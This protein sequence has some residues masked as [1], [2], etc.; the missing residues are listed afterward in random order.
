MVYD[1][2]D[3]YD[4]CVQEKQ[5][6]SV[7]SYLLY[8]ISGYMCCGVAQR[9]WATGEILNGTACT[10]SGNASAWG[11]KTT[12]SGNIATA[13]G[14]E[15]IASGENATAF[16]SK[17]IASGMNATTFGYQTKAEKFL[18]T[19]FGSNT[20]AAV[21]NA[22]AFGEWTKAS[23]MCATAWGK[24][25]EGKTV[26]AE[27]DVSTAFGRFSMA[28][29]DNSLAALGGITEEGADNSAAIGNRAKVIC[30]DTVA[31]GSEAV[32]NRA[33]G[34][35]GFYF[36]GGATPA[37]LA[38]KSTHAAIAVGS[39]SVTRQIIGVAAGSQDTD[40]VNLAQLKQAIASVGP[41]G[42]MNSLQFAGDDGP[43][44]TKTDGQKLEILGGA[45]P[46]NLSENNIGVSSE[47]GALRIKLS[48]D[49]QGIHSITTESGV[50][51]DENGQ[52]AG[53]KKITGV[54]AG[55]AD[56][57]AVNVKQL[58]QAIAS[59]GGADLTAVNNRISRMD[60]KVN[61]VGAG[62]AALAALHPL[63][64]DNKFDV[65]AGFGNY[66]NANALALGLF[67]RPAENVMFSLGGSLGNGE[68][69]VNAGVTFALD[70]GKGVRVSKAAMAR[71]I[72]AL[73]DEN[74]A[75][76]QE[77]VGI[78]QENLVIK[79]KLAAQDREIGALKE[80]LARLEK[81][82]GK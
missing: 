76:K 74:A 29:A 37:G 73:T 45:A 65:A 27:G 78:K 1:K 61:K 60:S 56:T 36:G 80:A 31:L 52:H 18:S 6:K 12:A 43:I 57:D 24:G 35:A 46:A 81:R 30:A 77:N 16:G 59:V 14:A 64:M 33:A 41:G 79:E 2:E 23:G 75:M 47:D 69:L 40:A 66:R 19:A 42:G 72:S 22:T 51:I 21:K 82:M 4:D 32:A 70:K 54:A 49:I 13:F 11:W 48:K 34:E 39:D 63:D 44:L 67:Y 68:N 28:F 10:V 17:T 71:K 20:K 26:I 55:E 5:E 25:Q 53:D 58:N 50:K 9:A 7:G 3:Y 62:A 15:T 8:I 38:W